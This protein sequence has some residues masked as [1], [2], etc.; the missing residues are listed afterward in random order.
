MEILVGFPQGT[1]S[2]HSEELGLHAAALTKVALV[3]AGP[4]GAVP[5]A[6]EGLSVHPL[7][8]PG[9]PR[10]FRGPV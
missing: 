1:L 7:P 3:P 2:A 6:E 9:G 10:A 4:M 8:P 5:V